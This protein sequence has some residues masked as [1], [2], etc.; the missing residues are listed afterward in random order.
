[1][2]TAR[3]LTVSR[4][5]PCILGEGGSAQPPWMQTPPGYRPLP[6]DAD[7]PPPECRP[8]LHLDAD[9]LPLDAD[10]LPLDAEPSPGCRP[11]P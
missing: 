8:L 2:Y 9:P 7:H 3:S 10:P 11:L 4:S 5:I 6:L 1:M